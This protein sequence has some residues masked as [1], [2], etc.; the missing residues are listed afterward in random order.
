MFWDR[1]RAVDYFMSQYNR[2]DPEQYTFRPNAHEFSG[3]HD[4]ELAL[5]KLYLECASACAEKQTLL[6]RLNQL[7]KYGAEDTRAYNSA[8]YKGIIKLEASEILKK[9]ETGFLSF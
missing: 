2:Y 9:I 1:A 8:E 3:V 6:S 5:Q 4:T 7:A